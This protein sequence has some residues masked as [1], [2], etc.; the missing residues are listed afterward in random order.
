N[1]KVREKIKKHAIWR[2]RDA[3]GDWFCPYCAAATEI[4]FPPDRSEPV[5]FDRFVDKVI[6]HLGSCSSYK[7]KGAQ[8]KSKAH[9]ADVLAKA[10][11]TSSLRTTFRTKL[12]EDRLF[13]VTDE[14]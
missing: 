14:V 13:S 12:I 11:A 4:K 7:E 1:A 2:A 8:I 9:M 5:Y 3:E 10:N 6:D